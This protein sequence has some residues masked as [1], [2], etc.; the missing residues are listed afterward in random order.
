LQLG[1]RLHRFQHI[2]KPPPGIDDIVRGRG[3]VFVGQFPGELEVDCPTY[4]VEA[5]IPK[6]PYAVCFRIADMVQGSAGLPKLEVEFLDGI[7][8]FA[9]VFQYIEGDPVEGR[10]EL[11]VIPVEFGL[12]HWLLFY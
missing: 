11:K 10:S 2:L 6:H 9:L 8:R 4:P 7:L 5:E 12:S 1:K 3:E